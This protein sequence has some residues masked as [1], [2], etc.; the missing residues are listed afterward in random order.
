MEEKKKPQEDKLMVG[1]TSSIDVSVSQYLD[2]DVHPSQSRE[3]EPSISA[4][5]EQM[6]SK[7]AKS[8][9]PGRKRK[10]SI[11]SS[12][13]RVSKYSLSKLGFLKR[14]KETKIKLPKFSF[15]KSDSRL[16]KKS[17]PIEAEVA[18]P[19]EKIEKP[20]K[21]EGP[22]Y[23]HIPLK[24]P[25]GET[26][27]FSHLEF[28]D[29][30]NKPIIAPIKEETKEEATEQ[31]ET[32]ETPIDPTS[33][34][35]FIILTA[36]SD[37]EILDDTPI[38]E[39]PSETDKKFFDNKR[40][41][42]LKTIARDVVDRYSP[43]TKRRSITNKEGVIIEEIEDELD[44]KDEEPNQEIIEEI[45]EELPVVEV[46][47][48]S[49]VE[50]VE[51]VEE[52]KSV[53]ADDPMETEEIEIKEP[54]K[55]KKKGKKEKAP[56]LKIPESRKTDDDKL[57]E[58]DDIK[59]AVN[60][61]DD[62]KVKETLEMDVAKQVN[63]DVQQVTNISE[64]E[65]PIDVINNQ[66]SEDIKLVKKNKD[67]EPMD[68]PKNQIT[69]VAEKQD[70]VTLKQQDK[71]IVEDKP[72]Q[73][74]TIVEQDK[75][76]MEEEEI[77]VNQQ[78]KIIIEDKPMEVNEAV[79]LDEQHNVDKR[80]TQMED[81][82][83]E[84]KE[85][86]T[87]EDTSEKS[88]EEIKPII[89]KSILKDDKSA[90][91]TNKQ[92]EETVKK[93]D[94]KSAG[95]ANKKEPL[96]SRLKGKFTK[97]KVEE[98]KAPVKTPVVVAK[99]SERNKDT[100]ESY[101]IPLHS[102]ES[103]DRESLDLRLKEDII[104][105][106]PID[107]I[108][109]PNL[110]DVTQ[111]ETLVEEEKPIDVIDE[112]R[113]E[114]DDKTTLKE[115][116]IDDM[117]MQDDTNIKAVDEVNVEEEVKPINVSI[118][119]EVIPVVE[120]ERIKD[121]IKMSVDEEDGLKTESTVVEV[122]AE[123]IKEDVTELKK[124]SPILKKR[125]SFKRR[126]K[127]EKE[128]IY[129]D[130]L[131]A[132]DNANISQ[133][134]S[135]DE[136]KTYLDGKIMKDTSL[137]EDYDKWSK[138]ND[139]EYEPINPPEEV[140]HR[141]TKAS[142][143]VT[144]SDIEFL[145]ARAAD[146]EMRTTGIITVQDQQSKGVDAIFV[147]L[148]SAL[149]EPEVEEKK[150][151]PA[152]GHGK[153]FQEAIKHQATNL[154]RQAS[155]LGEK[156]S[157]QAEKIHTRVKS[158]KRPKMD[159]PKF[160][161]PNLPTLKISKPN[162]PKFNRPK[163][164]EFKRPQFKKPSMPHFKKPNLPHI[165]KPNISFTLP[166]RKEGGGGGT[167]H[168]SRQY[169]TESN[170]G[171][172]KRNIFDFSTYP[173]LFKKKKEQDE[174]EVQTPRN[175]TDITPDSERSTLPSFS[176]WKGKFTKAKVEDVPVQSSTSVVSKES[177]R[178]TDTRDSY[179]IP[180]HSD[181]SMDRESLDLRSKEARE[182]IERSRREDSLERRMA[183][184]KIEAE[185][186]YRDEMELE[187]D[188]IK[189]NQEIQRAS[190]MNEKLNE[191]WS[192]GTF[193]PQITDLDA[194]QEL[195][196]QESSSSGDL[197]R[198][199][200]LEEINSDEFFLRQ[201]G[202]SEDN[203]EVVAY[204][205][206]E[207]REAFRTPSNALNQM[208]DNIRSSN[209]SLPEAPKRR[210]MKK[211]KR[212]KT[213]HVSQEAIHYDQD[214][215]NTEP[216]EYPKEYYPEDEPEP[217]RPRRR[218][219]KNDDVDL[220]GLEDQIIRQLNREISD[221]NILY[222]NEHMQGIEQ[223]GIVVSDPYQEAFF[224]VN[225]SAPPRKHK[226]LKSLN[227]SINEEN[228]ENSIERYR[229]EHEYQIPT[230]DE[231]PKRPF[232][233]RS[234]TR[235]QSTSIQ[236][237]EDLSSKRTDSL[238]S[239]CVPCAEEPC[240]RVLCDYMG[241]SVIDKSRIRDPPLPPCAPRRKRSVKSNVSEQEQERFFTVPRRL[242]NNEQPIRPL[243]NYSTLGPSRPPRKR[244]VPNLTDEEKEN[245][246]GSQYIEMEDDYHT[247]NLQSG[248]VIQ[249]MRDRPLPAPP[250][251]PRRGK[252]VQRAPLRDIT[253]EKNL[254][255]AEVSVQTEP[256]PDDFVCEELVHEEH[257]KVITPSVDKKPIR[258]FEHQETITHGALIVQPF[259]GEIEE[260][261][262]ETFSKSTERIITIRR[263]VDED[264]E[265][266][267]E[268]KL[269]QSPAVIERIIERHVPTQLEPNQEVELLKT[270]K[271]QV[272]D[273]DVDRL[274]VNE[275]HA[276]KIKVG[277]IESSSI[278]VNEINSNSGN[279]VVSGI[280]LPPSFFRELVEKLQEQKEKDEAEKAE[281][282]KTP[283]EENVA[284][285]KPPR[286]FEPAEKVP[287]RVQEHIYE[288]IDEEEPSVSK[289]SKPQDIV[290]ETHEEISET[291]DAK[292][293]ETVETTVEQVDE[294]C[295]E[296]ISPI[297]EEIKTQE[298]PPPR[299]PQPALDPIYLPSQPPPSFYALRSP[300]VAFKDFD[301]DDDIPMAPRRRR[302]HKA[303]VPSVSSSEDEAAAPPSRRRHRTPE[304]SIPQLTGQLTRACVTAADQQ[305]KR[306]LRHLT[307]L[308]IG[309][310][311]PGLDG[312]QDVNVAVVVLLVLV[313]SIILLGWGNGKNVHHHH[314]EY[315]N[316]PKD[317]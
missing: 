52:V 272:A 85:V 150:E 69:E 262:M 146:I 157:S 220:D 110:E 151:L 248:D 267:E 48:K 236:Q 3:E 296:E 114:V 195:P 218:N 111:K 299:P 201:K 264:S 15:S 221:E 265:I 258:E 92:K 194:P 215:I 234:R 307:Q 315:F 293:V 106:Q 97:T 19:Q 252:D 223:P 124:L 25:P 89:I 313:A 231:P 148:S 129:E 284:P 256:L 90:K 39:T 143:P 263:E 162:M 305:L 196:P 310:S 2:K 30:K 302:P 144:D 156:A 266:P 169:S 285:Q 6:E 280:E 278:N 115:E 40:I 107:I 212:K 46:K 165:K 50:I 176:R 139:H 191:R 11:D 47:E 37:D 198:R 44:L 309:H 83:L 206:S 317:I 167:A 43:E 136:E 125:V 10:L 229:M 12:Y 243:R 281:Q 13:S 251:P 108:A 116:P 210:P 205:S 27:E 133:S 127:E 240:S 117:I 311:I 4:S 91:V 153:K 100:R 120:K 230:P 274:A 66:V 63:E 36:P 270:Q 53:V 35:Q 71:I 101:R 290:E 29:Q 273:L 24:P 213:P 34:V 109:T 149:K 141:T 104:S 245:V 247:K 222:E 26:D 31:Q 183:L 200:V 294:A 161:K 235:S 122:L 180:L 7:R 121:E 82:K 166:K 254:Q 286:T 147:P 68:V 217:E 297:Y 8:E 177:E 244:S 219:K 105:D 275:L 271:L 241:Y 283:I 257:D 314:W 279:L 113:S 168:T 268:F 304:P 57:K 32:P 154:R 199:G 88:A 38:P 131:I 9:E 186:R 208:E 158:I 228:M 86:K 303:A 99:Q 287:E 260:T 20:R 119:K 80:N 172:S 126:S 233:T 94:D 79:K 250:R 289:E 61:N 98:V 28:D 14:L 189:E 59:R 78:D 130:V 173:R 175:G 152:E 77:K 182:S 174:E 55:K 188:Y 70:D 41:D 138:V 33:P 72:M 192:R 170:Y 301:I 295:K 276:S 178:S 84:L 76:N 159:K 163:M 22:M 17:K 171:D 226:S 232:R 216:E 155:I 269:L 112:K 73:V 316:P 74:E 42:E 224:H 145:A 300:P 62:A 246:T 132:G 312:K 128:G 207:I 184:D 179:R 185:N 49:E 211:P 298:T 135:V 253:P 306:L 255:E 277:E 5:P 81:V 137:E 249:K 261:P 164:P 134:M 197:P 187:S 45:K 65:K 214:S 118:E 190:S 1:S 204:L 239:E 142:T 193:Q 51:V 181:E 225:P 67:D 123:I 203:M 282:K 238:D 16:N 21:N 54:I 227:D 103:M 140:L 23:I 95:K 242:Y 75:N 292:E 56:K 308:I 102:E 237:E 18:K 202:I 93:V 64:A 288:P 96:F 259:S 58:Q 60:I 291:V 160:K 209:H 87:A